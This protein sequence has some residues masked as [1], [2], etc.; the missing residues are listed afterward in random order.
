MAALANLQSS[1]APSKLKP[2]QSKSARRGGATSFAEGTDVGMVVSGLLGAAIA[3]GLLLLLAPLWLMGWYWGE[4]FY[5]RGW[6][7]FALLFLFGWAVAILLLKSRKLARQ[8]ACMLFDLLPNELAEEISLDTL[9]KF[10]AHIESLPVAPQS[11]FLIN[12][13]LR[14]LEHFRVRRST[15]EAFSI[16]ASQSEID[17]NA[18]DSSYTLLKVFIWA[19]PIL[20]FIGTVIGIS[21]AVGGFSGSLDQAQDI[22]VLKESLNGVTGGLATAFDTTLIALVMSMLVMFPSSSLQKSEEDL[23]N[24]VDEYCNEN[25]LKRLNDGASQ[26]PVAA[27]P[28]D[29]GVAQAI[30]AALA[31][32]HAEL[33]TWSKK[34][35][36]VGATVTQSVVEGWSNLNEQAVGD[37]QQRAAAA[38]AAKES[39]HALQQDL[40]SFLESASKQQNESATALAQSAGAL[41]ESLS[42]IQRG[43]TGLSEV[44]QQLGEQQIIVQ[45]QPRRGWLFGRKN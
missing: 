11:S 33:Q 40:S 7:P 37:L 15:P 14:G 24:W 26:R 4:L 3:A 32:H 1:V 41:Q 36:A 12:R 10:T 9:D 6:V 25:L 34:L 22:A 13:V 17:A 20:G 5:E 31:P 38:E 42:D 43:L 29:N 2:S 19:I 21:A 27:A 44:L 45:Q 23:L 18:V 35:E 16:L 8:R 30:N 28:G 39:A